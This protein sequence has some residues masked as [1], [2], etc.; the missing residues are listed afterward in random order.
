MGCTK[1]RAARGQSRIS[2]K[3]AKVPHEVKTAIFI[4]PIQRAPK[5]DYSQPDK[6]GLSSPTLFS[7]PVTPKERSK[8]TT[9]S[10]GEDRARK[11]Q[12]RLPRLSSTQ[13]QA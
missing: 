1:G 6:E 12:G 4:L 13:P 11:S 2:E 9:R 3:S 8:L 10:E 7:P 5:S